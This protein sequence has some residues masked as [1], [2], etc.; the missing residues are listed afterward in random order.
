MH[1]TLITT[2]YNSENT[3]SKYIDTFS[4]ILKNKLKM[5]NYEIIIVD[6][7]STD[8]TTKILKKKKLKN[9]KLKIIELNHNYGQHVAIKI[10][11]E[12]IKKN[13]ND[14]VFYCDSDLEEDPKILIN[15]YKKIKMNYD[16]VF[17]YQKK[18]SGSIY[19]FF[20][21]FFYILYN[22]LSNSNIP[23]NVC[24]SHLF[25]DSVLRKILKFQ[26]KNFFFHG[27]IHSIKTKKKGLEIIKKYKGYSEY[28]LRKYCKIFFQFLLYNTSRPLY[29]I[30]WT[31]LFFFIL[32][33]LII[34]IIL[35][36][37]FVFNYKFELGWPSI[38]SISLFF[39]G[40]MQMS[41]GMIGLYLSYIFEEMKNR[42]VLIRKKSDERKNYT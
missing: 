42:P 33:I 2:T 39:G 27:I 7:G 41:V 16:L 21:N 28:N 22:F 25:S 14:L 9:K 11:L 6:D 38:I 18:K 29:L 17:G 5:N 24:S 23:K 3:I 20:S 4:S 26:E 40:V 8:K 32:S 15:F 30:F 13:G 36:N 31:G 12:N 10:A 37:I 34:I 35:I 1:I 19:N